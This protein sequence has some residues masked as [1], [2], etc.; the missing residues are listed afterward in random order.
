MNKILFLIVLG[1]IFQSCSLPNHEQ[2][3]L[4]LVYQIGKLNL[5]EEIQ[6]RLKEVVCKED[7]GRIKVSAEI[8][9]P[10]S[11]LIAITLVDWELETPEGT[12]SV[13]TRVSSPSLEIESRGSTKLDFL[14]E[15]INSLKVFRETGLKGMLQPSY[16]LLYKGKR[17][18]D[19][20]AS[21]E[22]YSAYKKNKKEPEVFFLS[23]TDDFKDSELTY[24]KTNLGLE[25]NDVEIHEQE[26]LLD[27]ANL[28]FNVYHYHDTLVVKLKLVNHSLFPVRINP[29]SMTIQVDNKKLLSDAKHSANEVTIP[30]SQR[31]YIEERYSISNLNA[32]QFSLDVSS[33]DFMAPKP[34]RLFFSEEVSL[35]RSR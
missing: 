23:M 25:K 5:S 34:I 29:G 32:D 27:G 19:F 12:H 3:N 6:F 9:N 35:K 10:T 8:E 24:L 28:V 7:S 18:I 4:G 21:N 14:F 15:P 22:D 17:I 26:V 30:R 2:K 16:Q 1:S 33:I 13:A 31:G 20:M 11:D